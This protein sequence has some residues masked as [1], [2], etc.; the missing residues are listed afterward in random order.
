MVFHLSIFVSVCLI[1][2]MAGPSGSD[3]TSRKKITIFV[4]TMVLG[5]ILALRTWWMADL[6]KYHTQY[7]ALAGQS[8]SDL[9]K[10]DVA[11]LGLRM[12]F[13]IEHRMTGGNFQIVLFIESYFCMGC[14]GY[15]IYKY[16]PTP[17]WSYF[18]YM[19]VGL[20]FFNFSGLKQSIAMAF[21]L[22]AF[23]GI[24]QNKPVKF[25][26]L[27]F[28]AGMFHA[29]AFIGIVSYYF[30]NR[31]ISRNYFLAL[32]VVFVSVLAF[33]SQ[34]VGFLSEMYYDEAEVKD[35]SGFG[36]KFL[37]MLVLLVG[38][39]VLRPPVNEDTLYAKV[40]NL[41]VLATLIQSFSIFGHN[42]TRLADYYF[43]YII[44]YLPMIMQ[45]PD[46]S[47]IENNEMAMPFL[48]FTENSYVLAGVV[49]FILGFLY[50]QSYIGTD[51]SGIL[52]YKFFWEV[53]QTPW[54]S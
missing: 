20:Y 42:F 48:S 33:R 45:H 21:L 38:G 54:G 49:L 11:N 32:V 6:I 44:L 31:R 39:A 8:F 24:A 3:E 7:S 41:M 9:V 17:V 16:S 5:T 50:Y 1:A 35:V 2:L 22:L 53:S 26:I 36:G 30:A 10:S 25:F 19:A 46:Y 34:I 51:I 14:L 37:M 15:I 27:A 12:L 43:Q 29:P 52:N 18:A 4:C 28:M 23:D 40:F 47:A 13:V